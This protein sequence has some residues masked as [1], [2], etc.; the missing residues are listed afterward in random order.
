MGLGYRLV[1]LYSILVT[2]VIAVMMVRVRDANRHARIAVKLAAAATAWRR[3]VTSIDG[4]PTVPINAV[5]IWA[6]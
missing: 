4:E 1:A 5:D 2:V 6:N 3:D